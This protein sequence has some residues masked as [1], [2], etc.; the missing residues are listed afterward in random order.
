MTKL[1][2]PF[3]SVKCPTCKG[4][5]FDPHRSINAPCP[6]CR[7]GYVKPKKEGK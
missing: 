6:D 5:G 2:P 7:S 3:P 4:S 1:S